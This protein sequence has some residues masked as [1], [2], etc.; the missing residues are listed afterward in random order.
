MKINEIYHYICLSIIFLL[1]FNGF[2]YFKGIFRELSVEMSYYP[3][4]ILFILFV[5]N[6]FKQRKIYL[7]KDKSFYILSLISLWF[8]ISGIV[9]L[10]IILNNSFKGRT[11]IEKFILQYVV[12]LFTFSSSIIFYNIFKEQSLDNIFYRFRKIITYFFCVILFFGFFE[13][14]KKFNGINISFIENIRGFFTLNFNGYNERLHSI[15]G[16]PSWFGIYLTF[17]LPWILSYFLEKISLKYLMLYYLIIIFSFFTFSRLT[18]AV[19]IVQSFVFFILF[20]LRYKDYK[21]FAYITVLLLVPVSLLNFSILNSLAKYLVRDKNIHYSLEDNSFIIKLTNKNLK[22]SSEDYFKV[23]NQ[24]RSETQKIGFKIGIDNPFFGVGPG[25]FAF[26]FSKYVDEEL[27]N[28]P[29]IK[30]YIDNKDKFWPPAHGLFS[31][32]AAESGFTGLLLWLF[33]WSYILVKTFKISNSIN[34]NYF[35]FILVTSIAGFFLIGVSSDSFRF[36]NYW[37]I[38]SLFWRITDENLC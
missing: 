34:N 21:K 8:I 23:S 27:K 7:P 10:N 6:Y 3:L 28:N 26:H 30:T 17:A 29:E 16:E 35:P 14:L 31:R 1:P 4:Y 25:Q 33:L 24:T 11:G 18:S 2:P 13:W 12:F 20:L 9:N 15:C 37:I 19:L 38:L 22:H 32:I 5:I 36:L